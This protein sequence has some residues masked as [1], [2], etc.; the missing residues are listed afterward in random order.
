MGMIIE[1]LQVSGVTFGRALEQADF[2]ALGY[3]HVG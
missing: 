2:A 1:D 3:L